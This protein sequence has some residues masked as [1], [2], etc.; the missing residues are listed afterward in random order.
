MNRYLLLDEENIWVDELPT[1]IQFLFPE[2]AG[3]NRCSEE[4]APGIFAQNTSAPPSPTARTINIRQIFDLGGA[5]AFA[6]AGRARQLLFWSQTHQYCGKCGALL[7]KERVE[8]AMHCE[9]CALRFYPRINPVV[10]TLIH[11][12]GSL[13]L[14]RRTDPGFNHFWSIVAGFVEAGESLE[15][16]VQREIMEEVGITVKNIR[17][18]TSQQ[19]PF[20]NNLMIGFFAEYNSGEI[21][22]DGQEIAEAHWFSRENLPRT[23][24]RVSIASQLIEKF[25]N[26]LE[27][28]PQE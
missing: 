28:A 24:A 1:G 3:T 27:R 7:K 18:V 20:P 22:P 15:Q 14:A 9:L 23:P 17:Y 19:W 11:K 5:E 16:A 25:F 10:I 6:L 4:V 8:R 2:P 13:L 26:E 21:Q 12:G